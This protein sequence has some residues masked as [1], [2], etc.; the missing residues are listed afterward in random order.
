MYTKIYRNA[1]LTIALF[2]ASCATAAAMELPVT[3]G[4][5]SLGFPASSLRLQIGDPLRVLS[6]RNGTRRVARYWIPG[7]DTTYYLVTEERGYII[8][9]DIFTDSAPAAVLRNVAPDPSG[10]RLGD[11]IDAVKAKHPG[12]KMDPG[13]NGEPSIFGKISERTVAAYAFKN[14]RAFRMDWRDIAMAS[15]LPELSP[16]T[17][18]AGDSYATAIADV[19]QNES[20]GVSWEYRYLAFNPCA[21]GDKGSW[22]LKGQSLLHA[23]GRAYDRLHVVCPATKTERDFYFDITSYFGKM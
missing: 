10:I 11:T 18:P 21:D 5:V 7:A 23:N 2:A 15:N 12:F 1:A 4:Y 20:D 9:F 6:F 14:G 3:W 13:E 16:L 22:Q 19:Q 8:G 17:D